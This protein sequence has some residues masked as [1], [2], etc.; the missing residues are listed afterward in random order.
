MN[1]QSTPK[2]SSPIPQRH[3]SRFKNEHGFTKYRYRGFEVY[4]H[5]YYAPDKRY[6]WEAVDTI[7]GCADFHA[8]TKRQ[9][10]QL[11]DESLGKETQK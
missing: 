9:I 5:G 7:T 1:T 3:M 2:P 10:K 4:C 11:I 8:T 6:W